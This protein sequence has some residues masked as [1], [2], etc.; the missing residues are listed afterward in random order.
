[1]S[2]ILLVSAIALLALVALFSLMTF[3][4]VHEQNSRQKGITECDYQYDTAELDYGSKSFD[5]IYAKYRACVA[6]VNGIDL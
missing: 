5:Q 1:M 4:A 2:K 3:L 6:D